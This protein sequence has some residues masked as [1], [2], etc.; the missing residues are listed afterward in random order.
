MI[1]AYIS[2]FYRMHDSVKKQLVKLEND[3]N[4]MIKKSDCSEYSINLLKAKADELRKE[5]NEFERIKSGL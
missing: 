1:E 3:I 2:E 5:L 4:V